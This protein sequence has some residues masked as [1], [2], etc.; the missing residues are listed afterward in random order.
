MYK[1][2]N[3][4]KIISFYLLLSRI[5]NFMGPEVPRRPIRAVGRIW[6]IKIPFRADKND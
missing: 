4:K 6:I 3:V 2:Y 5:L 1:G